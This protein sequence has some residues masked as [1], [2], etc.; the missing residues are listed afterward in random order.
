M[1][2]IL[3]L[4]TIVLSFVLASMMSVYPLSFELA[5]YRPMMLLLV[6]IFW[7]IY[8][9]K[10]VGVGIAFFVGLLADLLLDT[11]LGYQAFC[12]VA[13]VFTIRILTLYTKR[14][15][16]TSAWILAIASMTVYRLFLWLF[17]SFESSGLVLV[18]FR[19][20][21]VSILLFPVVWHILTFIQRKLNR[22]PTF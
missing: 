13:S 16:L 1:N 3:F 9:P 8:Q 10:W 22:S 19:G 14:L 21:V 4:L 7:V 15:D 5:R 6:L 12:A 17:H 18:G 2:R 11:H 20:Y